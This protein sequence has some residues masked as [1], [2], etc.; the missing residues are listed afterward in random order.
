MK[1][2]LILSN[3]PVDDNQGVVLFFIILIIGIA[4]IALI[5][6]YLNN[7]TIVSVSTVQKQA[8]NPIWIV[9]GVVLSFVG[10]AIGVIM[11]INYINK[12]YDTTTRVFGWIMM[13]V[14]A[15]MITLYKQAM[16][17]R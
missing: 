11:G 15:F 8:G 9:V 7:R 2:L 5:K 17:Q 6:R 10:G 4:V 3:P 12:K 14:G 1:P 13:I 16:N